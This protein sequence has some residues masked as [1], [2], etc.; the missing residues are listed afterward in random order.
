MVFRSTPA[1]QEISGL[2][3]WM[4]IQ[5]VELR[6]RETNNSANLEARFVQVENNVS[7]FVNINCNFYYL[8]FA[9]Q[10][11]WYHFTDPVGKLVLSFHPNGNDLGTM[12]LYTKH[13]GTGIAGIPSHSVTNKK[14]LPRNFRLR[15]FNYPS[16][17]FPNPVKL[18]LYFKNSEFEDYRTAI[19]DPSL[20]RD[21]LGM[22]HYSGDGEDC[23]YFNNVNGGVLLTSPVVGDIAGTGFYLEAST[24][25]FSEFGV[26]A[27][28]PALPVNLTSFKAQTVS[29]G[30]ELTWTTS[31]ELQNKGFEV[32]RSEDGRQF[33]KIGWVD[34]QG[35]SSLPHQYNFTDA[36]P[37]AGKNFYRLRQMDIDGNA[38]LSGIAAASITNTVSLS[39]S[40]N[41]V[42]HTLYIEYDVKNTASLKILDLQGRVAWSRQGPLSASLL[43]VPVHQFAKGIYLLEI[44][45]K[46]GRKQVQKFVK[47]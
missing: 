9:D 24:T 15:S 29:K 42:D 47:K 40:P 32:L 6:L 19:N 30:I 27:G 18:R 44:T 25:S 43:A 3:N 8:H 35:T 46:Q 14:Y 12:E 10:N 21:Q 39:L 38:S 16:G 13:F 34:G 11:G 28:S 36:S 2:V 17:N 45:D 1:A 26:L 31:Q 22:A 41:P 23:E 5:K 7:D 37:L 4:Q 33:R 20:T